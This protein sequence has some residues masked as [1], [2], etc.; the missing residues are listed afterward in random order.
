V[1][2]SQAPPEEMAP[3]P[4][5]KPPRSRATFH[6]LRATLFLALTATCILLGLTAGRRLWFTYHLRA[7]RREAALGHNL[8]AIEH[9]QSCRQVRPDHPEVLLLS[10]RIAR[11][12]S[13]WDEAN[14]LLDR[15]WE[16]YGDDDDLVLER[17]LH[18]A[19][20]GDLEGALP[21][22]QARIDA[23]APSAPL[24][25]EA[26][27]AGLL[28][29]FRLPQADERIARW[30]D[31]QPDS[32]L[33]LLA[34]GKLQEAR[35]QN[36][37][38]I[39][40]YRR[41]L[42]IDPEHDEARLRLTTLLLASSQGAEA[43]THLEYLHH[44][45]P[46]HSKVLVQLTQALNLQGRPDEARTVL[47]E[48]LALHPDEPAALAEQG[49]LALEDGDPVLAEKCLTR[50]V[51]FD[52]SEPT[53][54]YHLLLALNR[55]GKK[56]EIAKQQEALEKMQADAARLEELLSVG[57][58]RD[59]DN[60]ALYHEVAMIA[61]RAGR[62]REA[63]RWLRNALQV[64]PGHAPTHRALATY[65]YQTGNPIL[66]ARHRA[67]AQRVGSSPEP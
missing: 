14:L 49:R 9:L 20:E 44:R 45:L 54:R 28:Y 36:R 23:G 51:Q 61:L 39:R 47:A 21:P 30:L 63:L 15:Y 7:A 5:A 6:A 12:G 16:L 2:E 27:V 25:R 4:T 11:R 17:L 48:C 66:S 10:A 59:P 34:Q 19:T 13:A 53:P 40:T 33:A 22:L 42:E 8:P 55:N 57:L 60:P 41:L 29:R 56:A 24:A 1:T 52:P 64:D 62:S 58:P 18:R 35:E 50:A 26:I 43:L 37:E 31:A 46:D 65:Y 32:T 38:A 3:R 67:L